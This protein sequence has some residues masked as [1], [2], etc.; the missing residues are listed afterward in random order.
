MTDKEKLELLLDL[1]DRMSAEAKM[2]LER[3]DPATLRWL[4]KARPEEILQLEEGIRLVSASRTVGKFTKW[5]FFTVI[6]IFAA[7]VTGSE[8]ILKIVGAFR[9][10][11]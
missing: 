9:G 2:F 1:S 10:G 11:H 4:T 8:W 3:A 7:A 5:A 6:G